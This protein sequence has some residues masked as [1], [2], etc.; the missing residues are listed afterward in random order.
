MRNHKGRDSGTEL[1]DTTKRQP[2][3]G[4][5]QEE[6]RSDYQL[7]SHFSMTDVCVKSSLD[8]CLPST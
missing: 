8:Q 7:A 6:Q 5:Q 4:Q 1:Q 2:P 3:N